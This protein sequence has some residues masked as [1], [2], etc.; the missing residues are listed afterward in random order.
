MTGEW[1]I[2]EG[3][4]NDV[5]DILHLWRDA[6]STVSV[7]DTADDIR[8]VLDSPA[9]MLN[10]A[11]IEERIIGTVIGTFEGWRGNIYRMAVHR[12]YRRQGIASGLL[13]S[14]GDFFDSGGA[15]RITALVESE[16]PWA[17]GFW[18]SMGYQYHQGMA[19]YYLNRSN[20][21]V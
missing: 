7:T 8:C 6:D 9:V 13:D 18:E 11:L 2:R 16:H 14:V 19:R 15:K 10:V 4:S 12:D 21:G 3:Q 17:A 5:P 1:S 20:T